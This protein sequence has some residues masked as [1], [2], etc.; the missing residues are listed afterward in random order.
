VTSTAD[1]SREAEPRCGVLHRSSAQS[2]RSRGRSCRQSPATGQAA[3]RCPSPEVYRIARP[4]GCRNVEQVGGAGVHPRRRRETGN[5]FVRAGSRTTQPGARAA[6][7]SSTRTSHRTREST[8]RWRS[9]PI[10]TWLSSAVPELPVRSE[11]ARLGLGANHLAG[12][13]R[14]GEAAASLRRQSSSCRL[15]RYPST[16]R[17]DARERQDLR[18]RRSGR[19]VAGGRGPVVLRSFLWSVNCPPAAPVLHARGGV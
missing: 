9:K 15:H 14:E 6:T 4:A 19:R 7:S 2:S 16:T 8:P 17:I 12:Y 13:M 11:P 18:G 3:T 5:S 10:P 1:R